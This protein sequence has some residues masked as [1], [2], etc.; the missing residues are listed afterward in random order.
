MNTPLQ[1]RG[2][3]LG[4]WLLLERWMTPTLFRGTD[5]NDEFQFMQHPD[6]RTR[7]ENH[8]KSFITEADF[9]WM[10][11]HSIN[12]VRIP[13]GYWILDGD[14][15]YTS[16]IVHLDWAMKMAEKYTIQ[17]LIDLHGL[18]GSQNGRDHS[19]KIG[20]SDWFCDKSRRKQSIDTLVAIAQRYRNSPVFWGLQ[21]INE[22]K[23]GLLHLRM[24]KYYRQA[25]KALDAVLAPQTKIIFSD[26]FTP[27]LFKGYLNPDRAVMDV[28]L[29]HMTT[30]LSQ[31][32][33]IT[34]FMQKTASRSRLIHRLSKKQPVIIGEWSGILRHES[35]RDL[36]DSR[37]QALF[38]QYTHLQ[39]DSYQNALGWFYWN[40]K[41]ESPGW[42]NF[43]SMVDDKKIDMMRYT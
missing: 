27:R 37:Q 10:Q 43:K 40:Y 17:V 7:I 35:V 25:Y 16:A 18:Q 29:Y 9:Q 28:H 3:N 38:Q 21:I 30:F 41:T 14:P 4:G 31:Y 22:P 8:R 1:L 2:V 12:A 19:G 34:W 32:R 20:R 13:I 33:S 6:A 36:S 24:R 26:A 23:L 15:P 11:Q 5:A 39:I 42:W